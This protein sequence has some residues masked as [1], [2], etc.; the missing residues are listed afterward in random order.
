MNFG[1]AMVYMED[2]G[3]L[4]HL[5]KCDPGVAYQALRRVTAHKLGLRPCKACEALV[6]GEAA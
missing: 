2:G 4:Y 1:T 3:K 5:R 6:K